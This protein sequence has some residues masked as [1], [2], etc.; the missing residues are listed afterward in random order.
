MGCIARGTAEM[1]MLQ[2]LPALYLNSSLQNDYANNSN[3]TNH[4][5]IIYYP[6]YQHSLP[7]A[8]ALTVAYLFIFLLCMVGNGL[9]CL[10]VLEN[11]RMRTVTNLFI[12][13]LAVSDLLVGVFCIPTT[14]VDN[15]ITGCFLEQSMPGLD[16]FSSARDI[17]EQCFS[18]L[19]MKS[20]VPISSRFHC[21]VYPFRPKLTL[22][23][24]KGTIVMIW[25]LAVVIMC[26]SAV[27]L[28]VKRVEHHYMVHDEDYNRTYP[29][30]SC[31]ENWASP[32]MRKVY[33]TVLFAHI[34]LIPLT[35]ITLMYGRIGIKLYTTSVISGNDQLANIGQSHGAQHEGR[36]LISQKKIK[37]IKMLSVVALLFTLSWLP[38]WTLMLLTDY[39]GLNEDVLDLLSGYVFPFAHWLA[40]SNSSVNPII[41]GYYNENFKRGFQ[42]VCRTHSC[43]CDTMKERS[44]LRRKSRGDV[45]DAVVNSNPLAFSGRN[46]VYTDGDVKDTRTCLELEHRRT[47]RL[48][49]NSVCSNDTGSSAGS[50]IKGATKQ[51]VFQ[52]EEAE[53]IS[54]IRVG[55][56]LAWDQ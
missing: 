10:I 44:R 5:I 54:P 34:Y 24:A 4:T 50:G 37:V 43:C 47:G 16:S 39:G 38:L 21:I 56:N 36:P 15:L 20:S 42:S 32:Q 28:T 1:E 53:K 51:K 26:P 14:L 18:C 2:E 9:V 33:T 12:L 45:R 31:F 7:V 17:F 19:T 49:N 27:T 52:M 55:K 13:N 48:C 25:G 46:R 41:Y 29:L 11:R 40:F 23:V 35:L 22:L 30:F 8:A 6:Y 3:V